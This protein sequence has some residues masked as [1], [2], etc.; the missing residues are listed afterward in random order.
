MA[1][2]A[3]VG[4]VTAFF[5]ATMALVNND[6]K[7][8]LAYST[9]SQ[10]GYMFLATGVGAY[11]AGMFHLTSHAFMKALLFLAAGSVM[12]AL[13][14]E[15]TDMRKMG[16]LRAKL[17]YTWGVFLIGALAMSGI[18]PLVGFFSKDLIL[19]ETFVS[20]HATLWAL[21]LFTA[22]LTA[23]YM[24]RAHFLTFHGRPRYDEAAVH[25]HESPPVMLWPL[26]GLS[27]L[28]VLGGI[29]WVSFA[30]FAPF[31]RF[32]EPVFADS[33]LRVEGGHKAAIG[34]GTL[35]VLSLL[36]A[37]AGIL[38]AWM[39]YIRGVAVSEGVRRAFR[40][41]YTLLYHKYYVDELYTALFV[42]PGR[43]LSEFLAGAF[44]Q[45]LLN[46][47]VN[48]IGRLVDALGGALRRVESGYI[49]A[50]AAWMLLGALAI[51][52]YLYLR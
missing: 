39:L 33:I 52:I 21:G 29:L 9:I 51:L 3:A 15:E 23:F 49:R 14:G 46:G 43:K 44:D 35:L 45:G 8:V 7:R 26:F 2:V 1:V 6:I 18:P 16:G 38:I 20:G 31:E 4:V 34:T 13:G 17:P 30:N 10:L 11:A 24:L 25:P 22:G 40:P 37:G 48:G 28:T 5:A 19:E 50:Y 36:A 12:H 47:I 32:L 41:L 27:A 42:V